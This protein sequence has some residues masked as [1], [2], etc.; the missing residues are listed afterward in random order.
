[1][2]KNKIQKFVSGW[3]RTNKVKMNI[4]HPENIFQLQDFINGA[5]TRSLIARGAGRCYGDSGQLKDQFAIDLSNFNKIE[6]DIDNR[7][8]RAGAGVS[9]EELLKK[10]IPKGFFLPVTPGTKKITIGGALAADIHGKNHVK[11]GSFGNYVKEII[12]VDGKAEIHKLKPNNDSNNY[13]ASDYFWATIGGMGLTGVIIEASFK[14]MPIK[15]SYMKVK[16]MKYFDIESLMDSM[17]L[18]ERK[19]QY[20][21]AWLDILDKNV[22]GILTCANHAS[23]DDLNKKEKIDPLLY[24]QKLHIKLPPIFPKSIIN[25]LSIKIFNETLFSLTSVKKSYELHKIDSFFYPLDRIENWNNIYGPVGFIQYKFVIPDEASYLI[26]HIIEKIQ[27]I[28][29]TSFLTVLKRFGSSNKSF[30]S[31]PKKG[32][33]LTIDFKSDILNLFETLQDLDILIASNNGRLYLAKDIRMSKAIFQST[34]KR[35]ED[36]KKIK[37]SLDPNNKFYS[38]QARRLMDL[39]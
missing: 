17:L 15:T 8:V 1:M 37:E 6:L 13:L 12:M 39:I 31:F 22:K 9:I 21:V 34:Y 32:W 25:K 36:W 23:L 24:N 20:S 26:K 5:S 4:Y 10:I 7:L 30:L 19:F 11:N 38:D 2:S 27:E 28:S 16:K 18:M 33:T 35:F 14:I 29:A 3:G